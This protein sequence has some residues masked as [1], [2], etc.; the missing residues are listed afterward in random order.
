M[1]IV[2]VQTPIQGRQTSSTTGAATYTNPPTPGSLLVAVCGTVLSGVT[3]TMPAPWNEDVEFSR[4][5]V[6]SCICPADGS[7]NGSITFTESGAATT[8]AIHL[9]EYSFAGFARPVLDK[10][11][12]TSTSASA[13]SLTTGTTATTTVADE[14]CI[15]GVSGGGSIVVGSPVWT[16]SFAN[17][18]T[19]TELVSAAR[20]VTATGAYSSTWGT[21]TTSRAV[22]GAIVTYRWFPPAP[23]FG[24]PAAWRRLVIR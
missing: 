10:V 11:V 19:G 6:Y 14:V 8:C 2:Q 13:T 3:T 15:G 9:Y 16:N 18:V 7:L 12:Q 5:H 20:I 21:W 1:A 4:I 24:H 23:P 22:H 17:G